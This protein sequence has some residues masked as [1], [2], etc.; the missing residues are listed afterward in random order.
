[1][2]LDVTA[3]LLAWAQ[4]TPNLGWA[5][6]PAS[7]PASEPAT[8]RS[9]QQIVKGPRL[10][11]VRESQP[12]PW[13]DLDVS[14]SG[15]LDGDYRVAQADIDFLCQAI[16]QKTDLTFDLNHDG[17]LDTADLSEWLALAGISRGNTDWAE[18]DRDV[19]SE[20]LLRWIA[21]W[22]GVG[23]SGRGWRHGNFDCDGDV[24]SHDLLQLIASWSTIP[25]VSSGGEALHLTAGTLALPEPQ[26]A[27]GL[28]TLAVGRLMRKRQIRS[29]LK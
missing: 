19:D 5:L 26:P 24:D 16:W 12:G 21:G 27:I 15:D 2:R 7:E 8:F 28:I 18:G 1:V 22:S 11:L 10:V 25:I 23:G 3:D 6:M 9:S 17:Q 4:G 14:A 20:D 29:A 13:T